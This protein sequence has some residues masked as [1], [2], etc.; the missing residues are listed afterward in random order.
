MFELMSNLQFIATSAIL[1]MA[2]LVVGFLVW[3]EKRPRRSLMPSLLPT[4]PILFLTGIVILLATVH[5][6]HVVAPGSLPQQ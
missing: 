1:I 4:T 5:L 6:V 2:L 3:L